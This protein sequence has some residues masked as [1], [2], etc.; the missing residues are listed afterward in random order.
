MSP[1]LRPAS[2]TVIP[3]SS[4]SRPDERREVVR[5]PD[6]LRRTD[7]RGAGARGDELLS[8]RRVGALRPLVLCFFF[9]I[10]GSLLPLSMSC[11][12]RSSDED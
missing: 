3:P 6:E 8:E 12:R 9:A 5:P 2:R 7:I 10:R 1:P 11:Q 4:G